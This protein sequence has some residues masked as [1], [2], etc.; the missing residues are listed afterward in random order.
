MQYITE[1]ENPFFKLL[2]DAQRYLGHRTRNFLHLAYFPVDGLCHGG[3]LPRGYEDII[4]KMD[5]PVTFSRYTKEAVD[6]QLGIDVPMIYHGINT[7]KYFPMDTASA[8]EKLGLTPGTFI[9]GMVGVNR[10]RKLF[11][12]LIPAFA[13]FCQDKPEARLILFTVPNVIPLPGSH[14]LVD[15]MRQ[16]EVLDRYIDTSRIFRCRDD[17]MNMVYNA[18]DV[19]VLC[20]QGE[21]FGLPITH[22]HAVAKPILVTDC[23]SC[24]ELTA[25]EVER[26]KVRASFIA[27]G[28]NTVRYL[29]DIDDLAAKLELLYHDRSLLEEIGRLGLKRVQE[30]FDYDRAIMPQWR[31]LLGR[32]QEERLPAVKARG[33]A[34]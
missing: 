14:D 12:D 22:H 31:E 30:E 9:V 33:Q 29:T 2:P 11:E 18:I 27:A 10:E 15:L 1:P 7:E 16:Y 24:T 32:L 25:H 23:T 34:S 21:G 6:R 28:N 3:R 8:K 4:R 20:T 19:G 13:R 26:L 5:V 17:V